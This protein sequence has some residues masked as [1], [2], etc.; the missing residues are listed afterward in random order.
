MSTVSGSFEATGVSATLRTGSHVERITFGLSGTYVATVRVQKGIKGSV[1]AWED[2]ATFNTEDA[3]E[4]LVVDVEPGSVLRMICD[5]FTSGEAVY[6]FS[7]GD[8][9]I[10]DFKDGDG[11]SLLKLTQ[12]EVQAQ[13]P[14]RLPTYAVATLPAVVVGQII[15]VTNGAAGEPTL[16]VGEGSNWVVL[17]TGATVA[18]S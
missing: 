17:G 6:T 10:H 7:D 5:A 13:K 18:A 4:A 8:A 2:L 11:N 9:L 3:T 15:Y 16:A 12:E 14:L 1:L